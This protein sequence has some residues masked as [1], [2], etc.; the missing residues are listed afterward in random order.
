MDAEQ[1]RRYEEAKRRF[2]DPRVQ[3]RLKRIKKR[4]WEE[5]TLL[6]SQVFAERLRE[7]RQA[8]GLTLDALEDR[9]RRVGF[10]ISRRRLW[11]L[12]HSRCRLSLDEAFALTEALGG[13]LANM[14]IPPPD[15]LVRLG[16]GLAT[17]GASARKWMASGLPYRSRQRPAPEIAR[18]VKLEEAGRRFVLLAASR[19]ARAG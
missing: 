15:K 8:R 7:T 10:P 17:D 12:E 19:Q 2:A 13:V 16:G 4:D 1:T 11:E 9:M 6:P 18:D 3:R 14:L 5:N